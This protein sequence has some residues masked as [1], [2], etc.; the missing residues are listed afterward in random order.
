MLAPP[1]YK[2]FSAA[3]RQYKKDGEFGN[4]AS[5]LASV[6]TERKEDYYLFR[7]KFVLE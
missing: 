2:E 1:R 3:L 5:V 7:R 6:F 4:C